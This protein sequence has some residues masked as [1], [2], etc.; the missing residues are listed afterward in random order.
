MGIINSRWLAQRQPNTGPQGAPVDAVDLPQATAMTETQVIPET[1]TTISDIALRVDDI[2]AGEYYLLDAIVGGVVA[3]T[4]VAPL[5]HLQ[6]QEF[7]AGDNLLGTITLENGRQQSP[8]VADTQA[9]VVAAKGLYTRVDP[10][11][12]YIVCLIQAAA[13]T[14]DSGSWT[15]NPA[16]GVSG[17]AVLSAQRVNV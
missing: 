6:V 2:Q 13:A 12:S 15:L 9:C 7:D 8:I 1:L 10:L 17:G 3:G 14:G 16:S 11:T 5:V 4:N